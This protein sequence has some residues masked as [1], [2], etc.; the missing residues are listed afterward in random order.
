MFCLPNEVWETFQRKPIVDKTG[1]K[2]PDAS[3]NFAQILQFVE[4]KKVFIA[5][6]QVLPCIS[7]QVEI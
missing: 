1:D 2:E 4:E 5:Y 7:A 6:F 3:P